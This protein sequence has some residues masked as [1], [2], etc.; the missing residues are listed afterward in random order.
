MEDQLAD[1]AALF[2]TENSRRPSLFYAGADYLMWW[3]NHGPAP[4]LLTTAPNN[5][6]N[7]NGLTGGVLGQPGTIVLFT[8]RDLEFGAFSAIRATAGVGL[9]ED[10]FWALEAGGFI[11]PKRSVN[12]TRIGNSDGT[13]LLTI[14]YLDAVTAQQKS[15]DVNS[16]DI[17][18][19]PFLS[20]SF[21]IHSDI[22]V[23][24][25]EINA[26][27][28]SIRTAERSF[29]ILVGFRS[30]TLNENLSINQ[31]FSSAQDDV[32]TLQF[33]RAG[34]G[35]DSYFFLP[36]EAIVKV[37]DSFATRNQFYGANV[38]GR[39]GW[40]F[41]RLSAD[42]TAKIAVGVTHQ[43][44]E[45]DG[46]SFSSLVKLNPNSNVTTPNL[47]TPGGM[48]ALQGN[49]GS[50]TQNPFTVVPEIGFNLNYAVASWLNLRVGYSGIYWSNVAR[51]G[52]QID[53]VL[54]SKLIPTGPLVNAG[55][56]GGAVGAFLPGLEQGRPYFVFRETAFW[57]HGVNFG[58]EF[59]Y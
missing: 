37:V 46:S 30:L 19:K 1:G 51:P 2:Q 15:L 21:A 20:G 36:K 18:G 7:A 4:I 29:E 41:G 24:G 47:T 58:L 43:Q 25:Y 48:F 39:F 6:L 10:G 14:P 27:A 44:V 32:L 49:I 52:A 23:W 17:D 54:N 59:R 56:P 40:D 22:L 35:A 11:L 16:Q 26:V 28:H 12:F 53:T 3:V 57:A 8:G 38:G 45:I 31:I 33:P 13:P 34:Q 5:G 55:P 9:G 42:L 50:F